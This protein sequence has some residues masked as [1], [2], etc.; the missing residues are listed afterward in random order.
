MVLPTP[1][2]GGKLQHYI[3]SGLLYDSNFIPNTSTS[4][5]SG[6]VVIA[7]D[8]T[9]FDTTTTA[10]AGSVLGVYNKGGIVV[11]GKVK[12]NVIDNTTL[13]IGT[14]LVTSTTAGSAQAGTGN[15]ANSVGVSLEAKTALDGTLSVW[16]YVSKSSEL[17]SVSDLDSLTDVV[18]D[19]IEQGDVIYYNGSNWVNLHHGASG[20][21]LETQGD[22][23]NPLWATLAV[24]NISRDF[25]AGED[26]SV[27]DA[28]RVGNVDQ[29]S[30]LITIISQDSNDG[31]DPQS[32]AAREVWG[33]Q[34]TT[35][36]YSVRIKNCVFLL[37]SSGSFDYHVKLYQDS[38]SDTPVGLVG[39]SDTQ[40]VSAQ[41]D[42]TFTFATPLTLTA[43]TLYWLVIVKESPSG[44]ETIYTQGPASTY[45]DGILLDMQGGPSAIAADA[46][47]D[48]NIVDTANRAYKT[49][50][51]NA[52][53]IDPPVGIVT[54]AASA[55]GTATVVFQGYASGLAG[56]TAGDLYY[57]TDTRGTI[58]TSAGTNKKVVGSALSTTE[59]F[60]QPHT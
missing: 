5:V 30:D 27:G 17:G 49:D 1:G 57:V 36:A 38:G 44:N 28:V 13:A 50:A 21:V 11:K 15:S 59:L 19:T 9:I 26:V 33:Q 34:F 43:S 32:G 3:E 52:E 39:T 46:N 4:F 55:G 41:T 56:L 47:F 18:I 22:S 31:S 16:C 2:E 7:S 53:L 20:Q 10:N 42:Y 35:P 29:T 12:I 37:S 23:A 40:T 14:P 24:N 54:G 25:V 58:G 60:I 45:P 51:T 6:D 8:A 48:I